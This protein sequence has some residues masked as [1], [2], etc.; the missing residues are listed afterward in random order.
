MVDINSIRSLE[1]GTKVLAI[2][3]A[4]SFWPNLFASAARTEKQNR[5]K[6]AQVGD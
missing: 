2:E 6:Q 4:R 5:K 1:E 3:P